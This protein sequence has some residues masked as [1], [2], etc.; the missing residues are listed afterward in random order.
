MKPLYIWAGGKNKMIAK[1][2]KAPGIP[3]SGYDTYVEPFFGGGAMMI[4]IY[5]NAPDVKQ[6][7]LN[8]VNPEI[9]GIYRAIKTDPD[10]LKSRM[11]QLQAQWLPL[12]HAERK[13]F[14]YELREQYTQH[15]SQWD[16]VQESATL[17]FMMKTAFNGIWQTTK[18][19]NG[20]FA[21]P[22][23][24]CNQTD[25]VY[26]ADNVDQ[27]HGFLQKV[28]IHCGDWSECVDQYRDHNAFYFMDPPYID[29]FTSYGQVFDHKEQIKLLNFCHQADH[30]GNLVFFCNRDDSTDIWQDNQG[31]LDLFHYDVTYTAGRRATEKDGARTA[32]QATEVALCSK[33]IALNHSLIQD[34]VFDTFFSA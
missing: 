28:D 13:T 19:S 21:T 12:S 6:F 25:S 26:D 30:N 4:H 24:L 1:Y 15:W 3:L 23:G 2:Q 27:W 10:N 5:E 16:S 18:T 34:R 29:S 32:K 11:D 9:V 17:Y 14:Y 31:D 20:R 33:Q 22:V 8:D 7:V